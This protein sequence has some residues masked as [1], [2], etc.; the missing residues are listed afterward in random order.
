MS[1]VPLRRLPICA[2]IT[3]SVAV[4]IT[5]SGTC[6]APRL[7][8]ADVDPRGQFSTRVPI[9]VPRFHDIA[10][11]VALVYAGGP[12]GIAGAGWTLEAASVITRRSATS[13]T[14]RFIGAGPETDRFWLDGEELV[15]CTDDDTSPSC[16]TA[17]AAFGSST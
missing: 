16:T 1:K 8:R 14:P 3:V 7:A 10:P 15:A 9:E 11:H 17:V 6:L 2:C 4:S 13:G 12:A 5:V